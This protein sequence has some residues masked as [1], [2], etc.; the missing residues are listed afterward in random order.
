MLIGLASS[1]TRER[2][3]CML[4]PDL[5]KSKCTIFL[6]AYVLMTIISRMLQG[7]WTA[8]SVLSN[9]D[10]PLTIR[11]FTLQSHIPAMGAWAHCKHIPAACEKCIR[12]STLVFNCKGTDESAGGRSDSCAGH[13]IMGNP[14][15][16][17]SGHEH[18]SGPTNSSSKHHIKKFACKTI[19]SHLALPYSHIELC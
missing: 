13:S 16:V 1:T 6:R 17:P 15:M 11:T 10:S 3:C 18:A 8:R 7:K 2:I 9:I 4:H 12:T 5:T 19:I 14:T